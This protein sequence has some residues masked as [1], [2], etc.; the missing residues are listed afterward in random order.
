MNC[1]N[2]EI[3]IAVIGGSGVYDSG[4][5]KKEKVLYALNN[6]GLKMS[7]KWETMEIPKDYTKG[8]LALLV[9]RGLFDTDGS[10]T[11]FNNHGT[12]YPR[13]EIRICPSPA[14]N[15]IINILD[16]VGFNYP[17]GWKPDSIRLLRIGGKR[18]KK[19]NFYKYQE[20]REDFSSDKKKIFSVAFGVHHTFH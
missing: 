13:I 16:E 8:K 1:K 10:V 9:L 3:K 19:I 2:K 12:I 15:Q 11:I 5:F 6:L 7:P 20:F 14:K 4:I 17:E 18:F